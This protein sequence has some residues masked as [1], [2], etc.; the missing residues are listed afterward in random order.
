[1][2]IWMLTILDIFQFPISKVSEDGIYRRRPVLR[3]N[4]I[5][6]YSSNQRNSQDNPSVFQLNERG[7]Q[8]C[9]HRLWIGAYARKENAV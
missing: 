5:T 9:V 7:A 2:M 4:L 6:S 1:M 3:C 8:F